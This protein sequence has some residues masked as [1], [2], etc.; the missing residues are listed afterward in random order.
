MGVRF[1]RGVAMTAERDSLFSAV[2]CSTIRTLVF[3]WQV[4]R[5]PEPTTGYTI[6]ASPD[7]VLWLLDSIEAMRALIVEADSAISHLH[8]R[9]SWPL[10][11]TETE[12]LVAKLRQASA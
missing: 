9:H 7:D 1:G 11:P 6:P 10:D 8:Y 4:E 2:R 12:R 5:E 3:R